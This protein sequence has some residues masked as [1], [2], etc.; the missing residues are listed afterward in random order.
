MLLFFLFFYEFGLKCC[1]DPEILSHYTVNGRYYGGGVLREEGDNGIIR[2]IIA[3]EKWEWKDGEE[4]G[5][6][7]Q[8]QRRRKG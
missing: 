1:S 2:G 7:R 6:A 4:E 8:Q 3:K 5:K